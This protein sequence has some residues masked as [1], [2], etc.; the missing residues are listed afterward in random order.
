MISNRARRI[1][2]PQDEQAGFFFSLA[3]MLCRFMTRFLTAGSRNPSPGGTRRRL[4]TS[5]GADG[6]S[7]TLPAF[8]AWRRGCSGW[9]GADIERLATVF[10]YLGTSYD[11]QQ[12]PFTGRL[13]SFRPRCLGRH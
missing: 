11:D 4:E 3:R 6:I 10:L 1:E 13:Y 7:W 12:A 5:L 8:P 9:G 2:P